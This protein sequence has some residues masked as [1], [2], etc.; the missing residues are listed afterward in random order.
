M[1]SRLEI[2]KKVNSTQAMLCPC[3]GALVLRGA[4]QCGCGA[5]FV[6]EPLDETPIK[7]QRLGPAFTSVVLLILVVGAALVATKWLAL[8]GLLVIW[9]AWRAVRLARQ[10]PG[11][12]GGYKTAAATL[13]VTTAASLVLAAYGI[14]HIPQA[15]DNYLLRQRAATN[16]AMYYVASLL[17]EYKRNDPN[18]SYP[19]NA[20]EYK[21][22]I[23]ESLPADYWD[24][25]IK[26]QSYA[27]AIAD[28]SI[29]TTVIQF[30]NFELRSAGPDGVVGTDDDI[31]MRDGTLFTNSEV[32]NQPAVQQLR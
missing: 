2:Q 30:R 19:R 1:T 32:K 8:A 13:A 14:A 10:D 28:R 31:V 21:R 25:S 12:Y 15:L 22:A 20:Q 26:Y 24:R 23:G 7:V 6:G 29:E 5:R 4:R 3:C 9:S 27:G 11:W 16:S 18:G 17:E